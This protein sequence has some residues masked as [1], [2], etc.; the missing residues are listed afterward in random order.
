[1]AD[2]TRQHP[3]IQVSLI[4]T[5]SQGD[6]R[7]R[8]GVDFAAGNPADIVLLNYRRYGAFAARGVLEPNRAP[9]SSRAA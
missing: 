9:P 4:H 2:F 5:P 1:M 7:K 6:Y 3:R 8:L